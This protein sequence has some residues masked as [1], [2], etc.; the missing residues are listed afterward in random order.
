VTDFPYWPLIMQ[1]LLLFCGA[2]ADECDA[3][4]TQLDRDLPV[5]GAQLTLK[6]LGTRWALFG[7]SSY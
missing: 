5:S 2:G 1:H 3:R 4:L 7:S 6:L